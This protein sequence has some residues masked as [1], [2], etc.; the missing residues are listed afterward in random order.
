MQ[1]CANDTGKLI[2]RWPCSTWLLAVLI[3]FRCFPNKRLGM[4]TKGFDYSMNT[5][6]SEAD[7]TRGWLE[8]GQQHGT[9]PSQEKVSSAEKTRRRKSA[10]LPSRNIFSMKC[11]PAVSRQ[12]GSASTSLVKT[13]AL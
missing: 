2:G 8:N 3:R 13:L 10:L 5:V 6:T 9:S 7:D 12:F 4:T 1:G 11:S